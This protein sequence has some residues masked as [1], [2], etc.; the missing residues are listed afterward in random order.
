[1]AM[2][3]EI[4]AKKWTP[5][6]ESEDGGKEC[7]CGEKMEITQIPYLSLVQAEFFIILTVQTKRQSKIK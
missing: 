4:M 2:L 6:I 1:M 7:K 5:E 3:R